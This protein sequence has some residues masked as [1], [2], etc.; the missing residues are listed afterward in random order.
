MEFFFC[1]TP[2]KNSTSWKKEKDKFDESTLKSFKRKISPY[3]GNKG[4]FRFSS[5]NEII[6][7]LFGQSMSK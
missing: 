7:F 1:Y 3:F 4:Y 2:S 6:G 5:L